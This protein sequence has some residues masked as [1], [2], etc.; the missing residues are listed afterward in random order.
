[1]I[2]T[3]EKPLDEISQSLDTVNAK[4]ILVVG[5]DGCCQPPRSLKE[6]KTMGMMLELKYRKD[7]KDFE[8]EAI[9][10]LR[11]CDESIAATTLRPWIEKGHNVILSMA[12]GIGVQML[13]EIF[14]EVAVFP[15]QNTLFMGGKKIEGHVEKCAACGDC[16]LGYT[17]GVCPVANCAKSLMNGPC[18]GQVEGKCEVGNYKHP[19]AWIEIWKKLK[20]RPGGLDIYRRYRPPRDYRLQTGPR[21]DIEEE[22]TNE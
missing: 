20:D 3:R 11:Q 10:C 2:V 1:M 12:C 9:T 19:C 16:L 8:F 15:A 22:I 18:G 6:A 21:F 14:P 17:G 5:C 13:A 4:K 7:G